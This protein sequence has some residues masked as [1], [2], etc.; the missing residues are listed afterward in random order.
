MSETN[1]SILNSLKSVLIEMLEHTGSKNLGIYVT[2]TKNLEP[3]DWLLHVGDYRFVVHYLAKPELASIL[4]SQFTIARW[5]REQRSENIAYPLVVVPYMGS[6]GIEICSTLGISWVDLSGNANILAPGLLLH[7]EGRP[8]QFKRVGR[9]STVFAPRSSRIVRW[10][11][12]NQDRNCSLT[13]LEQEVEVDKGYVSKV[14]TRL[15]E[16]GYIVK[17]KNKI[18]RLVDGK[19]LLADWY[20]QYKLNKHDVLK[21]IYPSKGGLSL[22]KEIVY[23]LNQI[24]E[25]RCAATGLAA[26]YQYN[27]FAAYRT[28]SIY[29]NSSD[30][31]ILENIGFVKESRGANCW[32]IKPR[33]DGVF[34]YSKQIDEIRCVHPIQVYLDLREHPERAHEASN[35][36]LKLNEFNFLKR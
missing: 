3:Q 26:A 13:E 32:L 6:T 19:R 33:D 34:Y 10:F 27:Q 8:N 18:F 11:L 7:V 29:V 28:V 24:P 23:K 25:V 20:N 15:C 1:T 21:G 36:L 22:L 14:V 35:E 31:L 5:Q 17:D 4:W 30:D 16:L 2:K 12:Y 9:P